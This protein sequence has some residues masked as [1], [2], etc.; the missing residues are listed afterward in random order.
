MFQFPGFAVFRLPDLQSGGLPH[1][2]ICTSKAICASVQLIAAYHV[3]HRF[4]EPRHPP[5]ALNCLLNSINISKNFSTA[6]LRRRL[7]SI[8]QEPSG[9]YRIRTDDP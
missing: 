9:E 4:Q 7:H 1:S 3:L 8:F 5:C 6:N 2:E